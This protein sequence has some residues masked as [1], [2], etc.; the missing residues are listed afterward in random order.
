[1]DR[2]FVLHTPLM[3]LDKAETWSL[4][5]ELGGEALVEIILEHTHTCY[6]SDARAARSL[7]PWLRRVPRLRLAQTGLHRLA[8]GAQGCLEPIPKWRRD[9]LPSNAGEVAASYA[10]GGVMSVS[11]GA[12]DPSARYAGTSP[13]RTPRRGGIMN[14]REPVCAPL[15]RLP[16]RRR[17]YSRNIFDLG[18]IICA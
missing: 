2:R 10:D 9:F 15:Q 18:S 7:G 16:A 13:S 4:A 17:A 14:Q 5:Q 12:H 1:M 6:E 11:A 3:W 8:R